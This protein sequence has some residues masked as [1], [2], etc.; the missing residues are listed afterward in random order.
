M[1][2]RIRKPPR[3]AQPGWTAWFDLDR[4]VADALIG[5]ESEVARQVPAIEA[6]LVP[7]AIRLKPLSPDPD[8]QTADLAAFA[9]RIRPGLAAA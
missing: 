7:R 8:K 4:M 3:A 5:T 1:S 6:D 2:E 9:E